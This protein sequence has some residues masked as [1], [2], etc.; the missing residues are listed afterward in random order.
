MD[1]GASL[2]F[3][4]KN[5]NF[6]EGAVV[7]EIPGLDPYKLLSESDSIGESNLNQQKRFSLKE[8][9][10]RKLKIQQLLPLCTSKIFDQAVVI[11]GPASKCL[12]GDS[13]ETFLRLSRK[14]VK[15]DEK[16]RLKDLMLSIHEMQENDYKIPGTDEEFRITRNLG[17]M[18]YEA[19]ALD[20]EMCLSNTKPVL[21][22]VSL[23]DLDGLLV[24]DSLVKPQDEITDYLTR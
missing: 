15:A 8:K 19:L 16:C 23:V 1:P 3:L 22:R 10:N 24:F 14:K 20:C 21:V 5:R 11:K 12:L 7:L 13:T 17:K 18:P 9:E 2:L 6:I 4:I